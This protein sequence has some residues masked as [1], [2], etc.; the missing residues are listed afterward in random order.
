[1]FSIN[2]TGDLFS[3]NPQIRTWI[4]HIINVK[5]SYL[6]VKIGSIGLFPKFRILQANPNGLEI[7]PPPVIE[8]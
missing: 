3:L 5:I 6:S 7:P 4:P 2:R 8:Q 1:M